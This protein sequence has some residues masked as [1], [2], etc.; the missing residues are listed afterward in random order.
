[1]TIG[2]P[3]TFFPEL[4]G[5]EREQADAWLHEYLRLVIRIH[6]E[7]VEARSKELSTAD[8][9]TSPEVLALYVRPNSLAASPPHEERRE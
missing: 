7:H 2:K 6:R 9:L 4:E 8:P 1:M 3:E 5:D